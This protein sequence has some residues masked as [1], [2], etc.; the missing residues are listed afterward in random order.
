LSAWDSKA[1]DARFWT[2][3]PTQSAGRLAPLPRRPV[4]A[5]SLLCPVASTSASSPIEL[6]VDPLLLRRPAKLKDK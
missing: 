4:D 2:S 3:M 1:P 5:E 6:S